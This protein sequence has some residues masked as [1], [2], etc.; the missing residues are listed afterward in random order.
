MGRPFIVHYDSEE[1]EA[2]TTSSGPPAAALPGGPSSNHDSSVEALRHFFVS[3]ENEHQKL[4]ELSKLCDVSAFNSA[5]RACILV[6]SAEK[7]LWLH[8]ALTELNPQ[9][10]EKHT[11]A[12][13]VLSEPGERLNSYRAFLTGR[14]RRI[15]LDE[16]S[17][18][19]LAG[20]MTGNSTL[21]VNYD[22][23]SSPE[24]YEDLSELHARTSAGHRWRSTTL[25]NLVLPEDMPMLCRVQERVPVTR[26]ATLA[27]PA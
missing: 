1:D 4:Q 10:N 24:Q 15:V 26:W 8:Q 27:M 5:S 13:H 6:E 16:L 9:W 17:F 11:V 12:A 2:P 7:A 21:R 18:R 3:C 23:P 22:L 19:R 25:I 14:A 20:V